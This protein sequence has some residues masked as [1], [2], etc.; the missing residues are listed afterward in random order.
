MCSL[1]RNKYRSLKL[2]GATMEKELE[3]SEEDGMS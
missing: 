3:R 2:A 1:N